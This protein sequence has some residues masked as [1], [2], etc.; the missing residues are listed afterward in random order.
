MIDRGSIG[1]SASPC[2]WSMAELG[3]RRVPVRNLQLVFKAFS[4]KIFKGSSVRLKVEQIQLV[5][6]GQLNGLGAVGLQG[7]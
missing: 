7:A 2:F 5:S 4:E 6:G 3:L 1:R